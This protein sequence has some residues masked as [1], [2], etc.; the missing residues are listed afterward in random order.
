MTTTQLKFAEQGQA[1]VS[2]LAKPTTV[3][4]AC[5]RNALTLATFWA[6]DVTRHAAITKVVVEQVSTERGHRAFITV[7]SYPVNKFN[8]SHFVDDSDFGV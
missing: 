8:F 3:S 2:T 5:R 4:M 7:R 1:L 6:M